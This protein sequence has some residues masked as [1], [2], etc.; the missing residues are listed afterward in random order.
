[1]LLRFREKT[2]AGNAVT[3]SLQRKIMAEGMRFRRY[4]KSLSAK[5]MQ[6]VVGLLLALSLAPAQTA[7]PQ[8]ARELM[9]EG[10]RFI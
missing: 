1:M 9:A 6:I 2:V 5:R 10:V 3:N 7:E 8:R 4:L